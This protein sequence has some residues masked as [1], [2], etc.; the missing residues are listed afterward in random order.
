MEHSTVSQTASRRV[1]D[2]LASATL[3]VAFAPAFGAALLA[4]MLE[5]GGRLLVTRPVIGRGG[6]VLQLLEL[7]T[8]SDD[9]RAELTPVGRFLWLTRINQLPIL[10]NVLRG[11][12]SFEDPL[13]D[14][15]E[16]AD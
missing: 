10:I 11:E 13:L 15:L 12:L 7:R 4:L 14:Y 6:H 9:R 5:G 8:R 3:L 1:L 16:T 2:V